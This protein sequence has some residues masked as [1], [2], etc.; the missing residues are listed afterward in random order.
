MMILE[1]FRKI[2]IYQKTMSVILNS[3]FLSTVPTTFS[4]P[5]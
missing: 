4:F 5:F 3:I 1:D 2:N